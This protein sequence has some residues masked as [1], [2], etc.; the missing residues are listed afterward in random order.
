M[1]FFGLKTCDTCRK[2]LKSLA[3]FDVEITD[4]RADGVSDADRQAI[5]AAF[6]D[7]AMN[8]RS[9][10]WRGLTEE[11]RGL[12]PDTLLAQHPTLMKRPVIEHDGVWYQGWNTATKQALG[13][14]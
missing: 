8:T 3:S 14:E 9:T 5:I 12:G 7:A 11:E 1:R 2:A 10:T 4:V 13:I 6:G